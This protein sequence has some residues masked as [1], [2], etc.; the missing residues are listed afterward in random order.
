MLLDFDQ[1][2]RTAEILLLFQGN[3]PWLPFKIQR[4]AGYPQSPE[5]RGFTRLTSAVPFCLKLSAWPFTQPPGHFLALGATLIEPGRAKAQHRL[6]ALCFP[7]AGRLCLPAPAAGS[8]PGWALL[9]AP[10]PPR[11]STRGPAHVPGRAQQA[12]LPGARRG[13]CPAPERRHAGPGAT[14][15]PSAP[16]A[17]LCTRGGPPGRRCGRT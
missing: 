12:A 11:R 7:P 2:Q 8:S 10:S 14:S 1:Q 15:P 3:V 4:S 5:P 17:H 16:G 13:P 6:G 9:E